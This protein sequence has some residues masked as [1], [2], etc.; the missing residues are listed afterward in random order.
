MSVFSSIIKLFLFPPLAHRPT[1]FSVP[2]PALLLPSSLLLLFP[3]NIP[4]SPAISHELEVALGTLPEVNRLCTLMPCWTFPDVLIK[5]GLVE[6]CGSSQVTALF[7]LLQC[8]KKMKR[9]AIVPRIC[10]LTLAGQ[11]YL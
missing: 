2:S 11:A 8:H 5:Q 7:L 6:V 10:S 4:L 9:I 1:A 3:L